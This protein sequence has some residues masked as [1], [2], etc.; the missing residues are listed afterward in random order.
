M[1]SF[2]EQDAYVDQPEQVKAYVNWALQ[3]DGPAFHETPTPITCTFKR[4][5]KEY[6]PISGVWKLQVFET[7]VFCTTH[8]LY[9]LREIQINLS[10]IW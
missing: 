6:Y 3:P 5:H 1:K 9:H 4:D 7:L 10:H 8:E 2:F